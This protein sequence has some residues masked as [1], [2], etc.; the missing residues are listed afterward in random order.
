MMENKE[1]TICPVCAS[2][3]VCG[4]EVIGADPGTCWCMR[5]KL[6]EAAQNQMKTLNQTSCLCQ[7]CLVK[8]AAIK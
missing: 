5:I 6:S 3:H 1:K 4:L 2:H 7:D 8:M